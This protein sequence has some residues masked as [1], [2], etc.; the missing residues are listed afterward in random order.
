[1]RKKIIINNTNLNQY[2]LGIQS[3]ASHDPGACI[4]KFNIKKNL[5]EYVAISE[6]RLSRKKY[7]YSFPTL[8]IKYCL[9][10]FRLD[11]L[12]K[13]NLIA[14]DWIRRKQWLRSGP[15]YNYQEFDYLKEKLKF[16]GKIIQID[17]HLA[18]A[19]SCYYTS[20]F[21]KS[22]ILIV[23]G[24]GSD[25]QTNSYFKGTNFTIKKILSYKHH[26]IGSAYDAVS[27]G[28][29]NF[30]TGGEGKTMGLAPYG[31]KDKK[32]NISFELQGIRTDFSNFM[33]RLPHSDV[34][35]HS[36]SNFRNSLLHESVTKN[37]KKD[38]LSQYYKNWAFHIQD[39][40]EKTVTHLG[41][42]IY[43]HASYKNLCMA[44]GVALNSVANEKMFINSKFKNLF[45]FPACS[46]AGI[47]F[48]T[49]I[50]SYYNYFKGRKKI[51]FNNAYLGKKYL[52]KNI[53]E[54]LK[55]YNIKY[56][57]NSNLE[58][59]KFIANGKIV[60]RFSGGSEYGPRALGNR[61]ILADP[62]R[63][64]I[65][66][67]INKF[68]K[69]RELF[70]PFAPSVLEEF[71]EKYFGIKESPYMLRVSY[72]NKRK[73]IPSALHV[74]NTARVQTVSK[75]NNEEF[76]NLIK[77][78]HKLT[79]VPCVLNTSFNDHG[80]PLVETYLDAIIC[81]LQT[82]IDYIILQDFLIAKKDFSK[83]TIKLLLKKLK[84]I[85][86]KNIRDKY[87]SA[88]KI[89]FKPFSNIEMKKKIKKENKKAT[90]YVLERPIKKL[91][92]FFKK[93]NN[94][95]ILLVGTIDH[96]LAL[97]KILNLT[98]KNKKNLFFYLYKKNEIYDVSLKSI[99]NIT[100]IKKLPKN[101]IFDKIFAS[102]YEHNFKIIEFFNNKKVHSIYDNS[103]RS[104][105]DYLFIKKFNNEIKIH[106]VDIFNEN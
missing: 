94:K 61:S 45:I 16:N 83:K 105:L 21:S 41:R 64:Y 102:S 9:D 37:N 79:G 38:H 40:C 77:E 72:C 96:T 17:H 73:E 85:K 34:L 75:V 84:K 98:K 97:L 101:F 27:S 67:Y 103:S 70:R 29:I 95:K 44:G 8:S 28:V 11:N 60:A 63:K 57:K 58:T 91:K 1:M 104:I 18:H 81:F 25:L 55:K 43:K 93:N 42:D 53:L 51:S 82:K 48:G 100:I 30:G 2:I 76:Y 13:I 24:N 19:A 31:R 74:D 49:A 86:Q 4:V 3:Y 52:S 12:S 7:S 56:T 80:E 5:L 69:H 39:I 59:A 68:V 6:E 87:K 92:Y 22:A 89:L 54:F 65:R 99:N 33:K 62:R 46:D 106:S 15:S 14:S 90:S 78:F 35:N 23:D 47:P 66:D 10:Y 50:W 71:S 36:H 20:G 26:G 88:K 32:I